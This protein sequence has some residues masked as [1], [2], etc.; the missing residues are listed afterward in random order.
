[1]LE[2][3]FENRLG[4]AVLS[5]TDRRESL[6]ISDREGEAA[7]EPGLRIGMSRAPP[8]RSIRG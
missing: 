6:R 2:S 5:C 8:P 7:A 1:M 4:R 3:C